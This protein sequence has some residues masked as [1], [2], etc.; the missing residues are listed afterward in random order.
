MGIDHACRGGRPWIARGLSYMPA[1]DGLRA[2]AVL[3][4]LL[5]HGD[6]VVGAW[7]LPR[8]RRLLRPQ[9]LPHHDPAA[10]RVA[11]TGRIDLRRS[12]P[13]G[14]AGCSRR[15]CSCSSRVAV[16]ARRGRRSRRARP[17]APRRRSSTLGYVANWTSLLAPVVLRAVRRAVAAAAHVVARDRGAVLPGVAARR[18]RACCASRRGSLGARSRC[19]ARSPPAS[20]VLD[21]GAVRAGRDPSRVLLRHRHARAV[22]AD[23]RAA[24]GRSSPR[25]TRHHLRSAARRAAR[26]RRSSRPSCARVHLDDDRRERRPGSTA[27][28]SRSPPC[29]SRS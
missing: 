19:R 27:A 9:R 28:A 6:V 13:A 2:V 12:G 22:A 23:R 15:S 8:R 18:A 10:R 7:R 5:Y 25:P 4:V 26:L 29:S 1:L 20:A 3:A 24:R 11:A 16:Y 14:R 21:G 17:A